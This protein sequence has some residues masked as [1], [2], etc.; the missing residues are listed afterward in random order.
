MALS[1]EEIRRGL[2][3]NLRAALPADEG[4]VSPYLED[5]PTSPCLQ[6]AGVESL[7]Y[8]DAG[9][10][11]G[12]VLTMI[13]EG[14]VSLAGTSRGAQKIFDRWI[15]G[16]GG[17]REAIEADPQLTSRLLDDGTVEA[18]HPP[19]ADALVVREFRG[20][21]RELVRNTERQLGIFAIEVHVSGELPLS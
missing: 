5:D 3:A 1:L 20:Y 7:D 9:M 10:Y 19:A 11:G 16:P 4:S 18:G 2:A 15:L 21:Q 13:V 17:V 8:V 14:A 12:G 6:V